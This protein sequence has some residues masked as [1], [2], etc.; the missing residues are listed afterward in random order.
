ME[1]QD[2]KKLSKESLEL[3]RNQAI[4]LLKQGRKQVEPAYD[5]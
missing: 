3:L 1:K 4:R 5:L 2:A